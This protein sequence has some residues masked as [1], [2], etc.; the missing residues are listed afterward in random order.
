M[1]DEIKINL[2]VSGQ[3]NF[4]FRP[5]QISVDQAT[6]RHSDAIHAIG[7]SEENVTFGDVTAEGYLILQNLDATNF[8]EYGQD[9]SSTMKE[10]GNLLAGDVHLIRL[11]DGE[12]LRMKADTA[13]CDV[14]IVCLDT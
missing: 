13:S 7:T 4:S 2:T 5:G 3:N 6:A 14:R 10:T 8:V 1:A 12:T 9:D 11:A